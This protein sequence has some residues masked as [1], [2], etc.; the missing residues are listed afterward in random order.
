MYKIIIKRS[1]YMLNNLFKKNKDNKNRKQKI[2]LGGFPRHNM[3][4]IKLYNKVI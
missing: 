1:D 4:Q 3:V 2:R